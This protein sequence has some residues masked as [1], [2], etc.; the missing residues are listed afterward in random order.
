M[1]SNSSVPPLIINGSFLA[2]PPTGVQRFAIEICLRLLP[3]YPNAELVAPPDIPSSENV[4]ALDP[5]IIGRRSGHGWEQIDLW[6]YARRRGALLLNLDMKGPV[7]YPNKIITIHDLN[8]LHQPDWV[9]PRFYYAYRALVR[10]GVRTSREVLT[11]SEFSK[12]EIIRWL[13]IEASHI[14]VIP[15]AVSDQLLHEEVGERI[16]SG[17]YI[18]SV[19]ST[20]PRKNLH[21]LIQAF[22]RLPDRPLVKLVMVGLPQSGVSLATDDHRIAYLGHVDDTTLANLYRYARAFVYPSLYEGFG[23]PPLEAMQHGCPVVVSQTSSLPE[24][25]GDAAVY[26]DPEDEASLAEGIQRVLHDERLRSNL[27]AEGY[28]RVQYFD[29]DRSVRTLVKILE[30]L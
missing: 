24:V 22:C 27:I 21:R 3:R 23:I 25:C 28:Q 2:Q 14:T 17:D 16:V 6:L 4:K 19:A 12:Q 13:P 5:T 9:T 26:V 7:L 15:N 18:L 8:F 30:K 20:D 1:L 10:A 29:W 11:V